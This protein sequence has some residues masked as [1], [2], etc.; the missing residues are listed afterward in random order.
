MKVF[1]SADIEGTAVTATREG[2]RPGEFEYERS[3]KEMTAEVVAAAE[4]A[5]AAG[6]ELVVVKDAH[7]P[8]LNILP[9]ELPEYVQLIRSWSGSPEM[10]VE[11]LDSSF[12]AAFFVGYHNAAGEGGNALSHT[13]NGGV[14]HR[15][16]VN[17]QPASEFLIYSWMAAWYGVPSVLLTGDKTLCEVGGGAAPLPGYRAGKG[18][19]GGTFP[20]PQPS[21]GPQTDPGGGRAGSEAGLVRRPYHPAGA[22]PGRADL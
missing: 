20:G 21:F 6:A 16:T 11:G 19:R 9:E 4:G 15:I 5:R 13:I 22:F 1:I 2:C 7:G 8:G 14:V 10:M 18:R 3:R 12:D 17:G